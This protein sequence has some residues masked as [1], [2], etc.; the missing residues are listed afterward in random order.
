MNTFE[1][2]E[3][4]IPEEFKQLAKDFSEKG[5]ITTSTDNLINWARTG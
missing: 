5:F 2:K 1:D 3:K 4:Q